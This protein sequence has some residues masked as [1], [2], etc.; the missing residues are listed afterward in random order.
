MQR[1]K[2]YKELV[3]ENEKLQ[4][5]RKLVE[6]QQRAEQ[7]ATAACAERLYERE[8][9]IRKKKEEIRRLCLERSQRLTDQGAAVLAAT[10]VSITT[11]RFML[12]LSPFPP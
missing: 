8:Q 12:A 10:L 9:T 7:A 6:E 5:R 2:L 1:R 4:E 3:T 11:F